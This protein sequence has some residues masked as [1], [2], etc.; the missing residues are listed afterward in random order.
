MSEKANPKKVHSLN[1]LYS[2]NITVFGCVLKVLTSAIIKR[3]KKEGYKIRKETY[4]IIIICRKFALWE[5]PRESI[6]K[7]WAIMREFSHGQLQ[8]VQNKHLF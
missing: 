2:K 3:K 8:N 1:I 6:K 5:N 7:S 4:K